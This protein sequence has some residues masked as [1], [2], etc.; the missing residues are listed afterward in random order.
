MFDVFQQYI[1]NKVSLT[2]EEFDRIRAVSIF[3]KIR[4]RQ[5]LLQEGDTWKYNAFVTKGCLRT[6]RV[7]AHG[8]EHIMGFS[9]ENWWAGDRESL[10]AGS[11]AKCNI[12]ALENSEVI[13][14]TKENFDTICTAIPAFKEMVNTIL[15]KSF[16]ASQNRIHAAISYT[17]EE[18]YLNF[19]QTY[20]TI[21]NRVPQHMI[22][23]YLGVS[24]ETLSRV[25][26]QAAR[27]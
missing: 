2:E 27:K 8:Q 7:D 17:A 25:R 4:K 3:K 9:I 1:S 18:K 13:L 12:D 26:N 24:A 5:Y 15:E 11:P 20:P 22:A 6:Y 10:L 16:I 23:S 19:V 14:I 21:A